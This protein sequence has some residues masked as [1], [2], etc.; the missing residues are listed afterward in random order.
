MKSMTGFGRAICQNKGM[1][2]ETAI[3]TL[4]NRY[5]QLKVKLSPELSDFEPTIRERVQQNI[6]RGSVELS[7][8]LEYPLTD[9]SRLSLDHGLAREYVYN[10][11][12]LSSLINIPGIEIDKTIKLDS[13]LTLENIWTL[14]AP[15]LVHDDLMTL[16]TESLD[17]SLVKVQEMRE[18]EGLK[19][20]GMLLEHFNK[21][22]EEIPGIE[23]LA[24]RHNDQVYATLSKRLEEKCGSIPLDSGRLAEEVLYYCEKSNI[25]EELDRLKF[26]IQSALGMCQEQGAIGR[27]IEFLVQEMFREVNTLGVKAASAEIS[28]HVVQLKTLL[29]NLKEQIQNIE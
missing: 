7:M 23:A 13:L 20:R 21:I 29:D 9:H 14:H 17:M 16:L 8:K 15:E 1:S 12:K 24:A 27:K 28:T 26:H 5:F 11:K 6:S 3:R 10:L 22:R 18:A 25:C 19:L 2:L 4:N